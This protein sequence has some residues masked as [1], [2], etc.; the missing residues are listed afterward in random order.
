M[1][2]QPDPDDR[3]KVQIS[4]SDA[5]LELRESMTAARTDWLE[6]TIESTTD[7]DELA[8]LEKGIALLERFADADH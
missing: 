1:C 6:R 4:I 3:R 7:A 5:G 2:R 8:L